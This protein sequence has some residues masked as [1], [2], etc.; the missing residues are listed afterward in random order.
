MEK[1]TE[2]TLDRRRFSAEQKLRMIEEGEQAGSSIS[3]VARKYGVSPNQVYQWRRLMKQGQL[4]AVSAR[5]GVV[6]EAEV[7]A[8]RQ[9]LRERERLLGK[10]TVQIEILKEAIRVGREK[11]LISQKPLVGVEDFQ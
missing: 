6:P 9:Q 4:A 1:E 7:K 10:Q 3:Q 5:E 8:L 2:K 11:K